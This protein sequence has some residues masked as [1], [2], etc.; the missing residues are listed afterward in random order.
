MSLTINTNPAAASAGFHLA[1]NSQSLQQSINRLSSGKRI[2]RPS[3]DSGGL[4]VSMKLRSSINR[5][6]GAHNNIQNGISFLEVQDGIMESAGRIVD[7]M[8]ELKGM[9]QDMMKNSF[10]NATY[11]NEFR[12]LQVQLHAMTQQTFNGVSLFAATNSEGGVGVFK[13][14]PTGASRIQDNTVSIFV[15]SDGSTGAKVSLNKSL[16]LSALTINSNTLA[17]TD[18]ASATNTSNTAGSVADFT[19]ASATIDSTMDLNDVSVGVFNK[20]LENIAG[21]RAQNGG[22]M[23]R[24]TFAADN[25][26][27]QSTNMEA[28]YGRIMDVDIAAESTRLAKFNVL[29]QS[30]AAMLAQANS[31]T[32]V[33]LMLL[34]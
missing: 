28:A 12:D 27:K 32:D 13:A 21:L 17:S 18:F 31:T 10:D 1:R 23:S 5:L 26:T 29:L 33:A 11:E 30:S 20:A 19:F 15:S 7:R 8:V 14:I 3:D 22:T 16:L 24:L 2:N 25:V 9:S 34:R 6:N 4:A